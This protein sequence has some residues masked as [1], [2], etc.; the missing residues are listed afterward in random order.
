[1][2]TWELF[3]EVSK[4]MKTNFWL[5]RNDKRYLLLILILQMHFSS[6]ILLHAT[7]QLFILTVKYQQINHCIAI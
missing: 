5:I 6:N 2:N 7:K 4:I 3:A 1:M